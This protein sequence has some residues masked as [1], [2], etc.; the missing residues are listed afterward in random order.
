MQGV[1]SEHAVLTAER[2]QLAVVWSLHLIA[3]SE[4][5]S[6]I[7]LAA[8]HPSFAAG[9]FAAHVVGQFEKCRPDAR[10]TDMV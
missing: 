1:E 4:G 8:P 5:P 7:S 6:L 10:L 3:D 2:Q 9:V